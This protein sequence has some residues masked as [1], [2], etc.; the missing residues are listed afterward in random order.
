MLVDTHNIVVRALNRNIRGFGSLR[1]VSEAEKK[2]ESVGDYAG[3]QVAQQAVTLNM[4][5]R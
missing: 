4:E 1:D 5:E 2:E 3:R